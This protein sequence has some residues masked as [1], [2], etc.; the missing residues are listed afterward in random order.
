MRRR[1]G[2]ARQ[3]RQQ[4]LG[5][6]LVLAVRAG[7]PPPLHTP[8]CFPARP[9]VLRLWEALW[10]GSPG[11]HL[12]LCVAVLEHQRRLILRWGCLGPSGRLGCLGLGLAAALGGTGAPLPNASLAT[13][14]PSPLSL[15]P[16]LRRGL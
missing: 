11:L 3:H 2:Q 5:C 6:L 16:Q 10:A 12:Y 7:V 8:P 14:S 4:Q 15:P 9:Q 13:I 1:A